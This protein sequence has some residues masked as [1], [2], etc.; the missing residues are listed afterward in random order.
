MSYSC[1]SEKQVQGTGAVDVG[2]DKTEWTC[3]REARRRNVGEEE[4]TWGYG[5][6]EHRC[7][8]SAWPGEQRGRSG[9]ASPPHSALLMLL[10]NTWPHSGVGVRQEARLG[11]RLPWTGKFNPKG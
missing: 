2:G 1:L 9:Q 8:C 7:R 4:L 5:V 10:P 11:P 6:W 3:E